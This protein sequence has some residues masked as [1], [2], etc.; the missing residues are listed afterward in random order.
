MSEK[1]APRTPP[2]PTPDPSTRAF[3]EAAREG[4]LLI[5]RN[6][7]TGKVHYP[8]RPVCPFDDEGEV[9]FVA[10]SGRGT[11]YS[12]SHMH[13]KTPYVIAYVEL[14]EGPRMMTNIVDCDPAA[15]RVGLPV[16][17][18]FVPSEDPAQPI[19]MFTPA[20]EKS[21]HAHA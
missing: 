14:A 17:L 1:L 5:G 20:E 18:V 15:L 13:A 6:T 8:P 10:A 11:I 16:R 12:Y 3:W 19:P 9:E 4:R 21:D 2:A 7:K